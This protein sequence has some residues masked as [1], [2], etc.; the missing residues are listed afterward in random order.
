M[1]D[2]KRALICSVILYAVAAVCIVLAVIFDTRYV[3]DF[4]AGGCLLAAI[5]MTVVYVR[6]K[7]K[8]RGGKFAPVAKMTAEEIY[9]DESRD[10]YDKF[11]QWWVDCDENEIKS[12][13]VLL[14]AHRVMSWYN[15]VCNGGFG[16]FFDFAENWDMRR[17][18]ELFKYLLPKDF[19]DLFERALQAHISGG[20][21]ERFNGEFDYAKMENEILPELTERVAYNYKYKV[22]L[23]QY[24]LI[25]GITPYL[26]SLGYKKKNKR[27]TKDTGE[28]TLCFY[29]QGSAYDSDSYYIRPGIFING[30]GQGGLDF[31]GH[32]YVDLKQ[33]SVEQVVADYG[34]FVTEWTDKPLIKSRLEQFTEWEKRNPLDKRRKMT[35]K[36]LYKDDPLPEGCD[37]YFAVNEATKKY[38][39]EN[40]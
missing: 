16:Q 40:F 30:I 12:N 29:I 2:K 6:L 38:I 1:F 34:K 21:C 18:S 25:E 39:S 8:E 5:V 13:S 31:Y 33:Q 15:E 32:F 28:F 22:T 11:V 17:T 23:T 7:N 36:D 35:D 19:Y 20:D 9:G 14:G 10:N 26:K 37:V 24:D 3:F 4:V 27:W